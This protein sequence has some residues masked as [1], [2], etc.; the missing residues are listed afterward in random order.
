M[1]VENKRGGTDD[2]PDSPIIRMIFIRSFSR[3]QGVEEE[4]ETGLSV[5]A[6]SVTLGY[7]LRGLT[8]LATVL[9][10]VLRR[11]FS[12]LPSRVNVYEL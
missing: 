11:E 5:R 7:T 8:F 10:T 2:D 1:P 9:Q 6:V 3:I 12:K 4:R